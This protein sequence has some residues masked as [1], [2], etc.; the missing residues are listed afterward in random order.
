[1]FRTSKNSKNHDIVF[2]Y[3]AQNSYGNDKWYIYIKLIKYKGY[4]LYISPG[5]QHSTLWQYLPKA[6]QSIFLWFP[7]LPQHKHNAVESKSECPMNEVDIVSWWLLA[8]QNV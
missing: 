5:P 7:T 3:L 1:M 2:C 8:Y 6:W 4:V